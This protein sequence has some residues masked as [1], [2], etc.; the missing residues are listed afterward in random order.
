MYKYLSETIEMCGKN[1]RSLYRV[2]AQYP[3]VEAPASG[4]GHVTQ[5]EAHLF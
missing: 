2:H 4:G 3:Q 5:E 1:E